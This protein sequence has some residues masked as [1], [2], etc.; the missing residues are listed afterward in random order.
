MI[1]GV[2]VYLIFSLLTFFVAY[3]F[4]HS[5]AVIVDEPITIP[6]YSINL[7]CLF[8]SFVWPAFWLVILIILALRLN[9]RKEEVNI[10]E[11]E[12]QVLYA[13]YRESVDCCG[14]CT[15][16][17]NMSFMNA[18]DLSKVIPDVK[19]HAIGAVMGNLERKGLISDTGEKRIANYNDWC[20]NIEVMPV[21]IIKRFNDD[22][23]KEADG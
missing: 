2:T 11:L 17:Q 23:E 19:R 16:Q 20:I 10:S 14:E 13:F 7:S 12:Y 8:W 6:S 3:K 9:K 1:D 22:I 15:P 21:S 18:D 4:G 5:N